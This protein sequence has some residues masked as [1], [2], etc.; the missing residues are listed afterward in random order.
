M[1]KINSKLFRSFFLFFFIFYFFG[2]FHCSLRVGQR[3]FRRPVMGAIVLESSF[4]SSRSTSLIFILTN[5]AL[6]SRLLGGFEDY[7]LRE[8]LARKIEP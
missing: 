7:T 3:S 1:P 6:P 5:C 2:I 4:L 8:A